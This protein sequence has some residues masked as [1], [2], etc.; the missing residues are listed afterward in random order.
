[1]AFKTFKRLA[2]P[3]PLEPSPTPEQRSGTGVESVVKPFRGF[4][5]A[6][7]LSQS[8]SFSEEGPTEKTPIRRSYSKGSKSLPEPRRGV[9]EIEP[10]LCL[11]F[12]FQAVGRL[13]STQ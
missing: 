4:S 8:S 5:S 6:S 2:L 10:G 13:I 12:Y 11:F 9:V 1:M 7:V 3:I